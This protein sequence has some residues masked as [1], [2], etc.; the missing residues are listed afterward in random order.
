MIRILTYKEHPRGKEILDR[1]LYLAA[2]ILPFPP[3][4]V[5]GTDT[6]E[7]DGKVITSGNFCQESGKRP[8]KRTQ[9]Y[10]SLLQDYNVVGDLVPSHTK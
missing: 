4:D 7:V 6:L 9:L 2:Y 10:M 5:L 1:Y 8:R 3:G